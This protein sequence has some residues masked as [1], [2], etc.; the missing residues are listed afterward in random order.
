MLP[1][2]KV[3]TSS[4]VVSWFIFISQLFAQTQ[5]QK[6]PDPVLEVGSPG[7]W[8][9]TTSLATTVLFHQGIY[10]MWYE[11]DSG[12]GYATSPDGLVWIK[13]T[14]HNPVLEPGPPGS[15]D[16]IAVN[17]VSVL[18]NDSL[19]H[20]WYSGVDVN[21]D[22]RIGHATSLDGV[23]WTKDTANPVLDLG[24]TAPWDTDEAM[25]PCVIYEDNLF[26]MFYNGYGGNTQ[27]ILYAYS[28]N[29][30]NWT[31]Y[32]THPML[33]PGTSGSWDDWELGP[34][35]I[36]HDADNYHMWYTGWDD[37]TS[38]ATIQIGY[39]ASSNGLS[40]TRGSAQPVLSP[41]NPGD[42]DDMA[43]AIPNVIREGNLY[44][45]W[46]GGFDGSY[47]RTGYA[48][49][50]PDHIIQQDGAIPGKYHLL[51]NFPNPFNPTTE[52]SWQLAVGTPVRLVVYDITGQEIAI[53]INETKT[54]GI[55]Q[56]TF[57]GSNLA[58]GIYL[59][60]L[61]A[62]QFVETKKMILLK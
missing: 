55:H 61:Q 22:N 38:T 24:T 42:W 43:V 41:G 3:L 23:F 13:D 4:V 2:K 58:S 36:L 26:K 28:S 21:N 45:M 50:Q 33:E 5:W 16:D 48:T 27:R 59:Y 34:L 12:F 37:S 47:Y 35:S 14:L 17:Q 44:K 20:L 8:D 40:W 18:I 7:S 29:G 25:H 56:I 11:G 39:A 15:W 10:K 1:G 32:T 52:I 51:Q 60:H 31:G 54:A 49:S 9:Q 53:L 46:Y 30:T 6:Y 57:D 62:G 19:Y